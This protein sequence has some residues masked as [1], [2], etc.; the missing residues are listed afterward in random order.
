MVLAVTPGNDAGDVFGPLDILRYATQFAEEDPV[1]P[2]R[3]YTIDV[4]STAPRKNVWNAPGVRLL[5][6]RTYRD[7]RGRVD[8]LIIMPIDEEHLLRGH[9]PFVSWLTSAAPRIGRVVGLCTG[10]FFLA[11]AGLLTGQ[12]ATTHWAFCQTLRRHF[13]TVQVKTDPIFFEVISADEEKA[14]QRELNELAKEKRTSQASY[15]LVR[16]SLFYEHGLLSDA[17]E[18]A[19]VAVR[20]NGNETLRAVLS[21]LYAEAGLADAGQAETSESAN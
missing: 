20:I 12:R 21:Q 3:G 8:T 6:D 7:I 15:H 2:A 18:E 1:H 16:A 13:P 4:V 19:K 9:E 14:I 11:R 5:V 17:I 10:T